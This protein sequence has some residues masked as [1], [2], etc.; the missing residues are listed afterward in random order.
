VDSRENVGPGNTG[1]EMN[2]ILF[3]KLAHNLTADIGFVLSI[4]DYNFCGQPS[5]LA[6]KL[7]QCQQKAI[8]HVAT[9]DSAPAGKT[10]H[11][12]DPNFVVLRD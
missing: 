8:S 1:N 2:F 12:A 11:E 10:S 9:I 3:Q 5:Q 7:I 6:T 4:T